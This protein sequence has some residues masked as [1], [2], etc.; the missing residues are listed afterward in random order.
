MQRRV[1]AQQNGNKWQAV[2]VDVCV[3]QEQ[4]GFICESNTNTNVQD[5]CLGT[6]QNASHFE[7]CPAEMLETVLVYI[8]KVRTICDS[9]KTTP[10]QK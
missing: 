6:Q 10:L 3:V 8:G 1:C 7:I 9:K 5:I 2:T 4:Q